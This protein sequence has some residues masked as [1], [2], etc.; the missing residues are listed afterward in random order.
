MAIRETVMEYYN[1][2]LA[3]ENKQIKYYSY[4]KFKEVE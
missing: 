2:Y 4:E 1:V 3:L